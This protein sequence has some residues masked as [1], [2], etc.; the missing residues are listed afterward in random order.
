MFQHFY[1]LLTGHV[2][3]TFERESRDG[4]YSEMLCSARLCYGESVCP[5][6]RPALCLSL[7]ICLSVMLVYP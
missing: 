2:S 5:S 4:E 6:V 7:S 1:F 3:S